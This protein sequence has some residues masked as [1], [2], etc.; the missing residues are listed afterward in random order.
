MNRELAE[1]AF[2]GTVLN[3][4]EKQQLM[5]YLSSGAHGTA[6]HMMHNR[7][8]NA[9]SGD[10]ENAKGRYIRNRIFLRGDELKR[11]HPFVYRHKIL[12]PFFDIYR[13]FAAIIKRP[14]KTWMELKRVL[15]F[16]KEGTPRSETNE[17]QDTTE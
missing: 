4:E 10:D 9:L 12:M 2:S 5:Y 8:S 6:D 17:K 1:K 13:L 11:K 14:K 3:E 7:V 16:K 15:D